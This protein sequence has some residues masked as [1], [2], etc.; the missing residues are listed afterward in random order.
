M[1]RIEERRAL[2]LINH[3][4]SRFRSE[5]GKFG[6]QFR[7]IIEA[8]V[9]RARNYN[10]ETYDDISLFAETEIRHGPNFEYK[11]EYEEARYYLQESSKTPNEK[12]FYA[13]K[14]CVESV[15]NL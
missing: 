8:A 13:N 10:L 2:G 3:L 5:G 14:A 7:G 1:I 6:S 4:A 15:E 9:L 11:P 12:I